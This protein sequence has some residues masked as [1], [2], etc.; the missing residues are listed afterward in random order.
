MLTTNFVP[1]SPNWLDLGAPD[2]DATAAFYGAVFGWSF[3]GLGPEAGNYGFLQQGGKNVAA[4]GP[5]QEGQTSAWNVYFYTRDADA[6]TKAVEKA[7]GAV[8]VPAFDVM[9][10]GRMSCLTDPQGGEFNTWQPN[11]VQGLEEA[12]ELNSL[13][14]VELHTQDPDASFAWYKGIYNWRSEKMEA[15]GMTY[16]VVSTSEG[17]LRDA[18]FGGIA[19]KMSA[20]EPT[21][22]VPYFNV[23]NP[24]DISTKVTAAGGAVMMPAADVPDV[25]RIAWYADPNGAVFAVLKPNPP[26]MA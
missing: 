19:P 5:L 16:T 26:A 20:D 25:G 6:T 13:V 15:P 24:D 18:S 21:R 1:G 17:D 2:I 9:E 14:W 7:G 3:M 8:R 10:A 23:A 12:S 11:T 22:W 4:I